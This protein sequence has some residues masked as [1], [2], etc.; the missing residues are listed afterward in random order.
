MPIV[1]IAI[2]FCLAL[3][4]H[5]LWTERQWSR[6]EAVV[7]RAAYHDGIEAG[8]VIGWR[9]AETHYKPLV[10]ELR[11]RL[12]DADVK[13]KVGLSAVYAEAWNSGVAYASQQRP[14]WVLPS[15]ER[16]S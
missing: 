13:L 2:G 3:W 5:L 16:A 14:D 12:A 1:W 9:D 11:Q 10:A 8:K 7:R 4:V 6:R 15:R